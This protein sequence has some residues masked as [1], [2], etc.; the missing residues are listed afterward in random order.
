MKLPKSIKVFGETYKIKVIKEKDPVNLG[1]CDFQKK[2]ILVHDRQSSK[3]IMHTLIHEV[4]H[5]VFNRIGLNQSISHDL[6]EVIVDSIATA[7]S[8]NFRLQNR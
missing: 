5:A 4:G 8:E 3:E 1:L 6:E 2:I 7:I